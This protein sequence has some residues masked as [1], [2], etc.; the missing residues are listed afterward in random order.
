[1]HDGE[2]SES[3]WVHDTDEHFRMC[4]EQGAVPQAVVSLDGR[5]LQVN[6]ALARLLGV[7]CSELIGKRFNDVTHPDDR[8][9]SDAA[10]HTLLSGT[11]MIRM[12]ERYLTHDGA[13]V[14]ADVNVALVRSPN[15]HPQ[16]FVGTYID[17]TA[18]KLAEEELEESRNRLRMALDSARMGTW[19]WDL[20]SGLRGFDAQVC[21]LLGIDKASF[22]GQPDEFFRVVHPDDH[23]KVK[24]AL[25]RTIETGERYEIEYRVLG[26]DGEIGTVAA[27]GGLVR[28]AAGKPLRIDGVVWDRSEQAR[29]LQALRESEERFRELAEALP[30]TIFEID[31]QGR[32]YYSNQQGLR[33]FGVS[34]AEIQAGLLVRN[35]VSPD[36]QPAVQQRVRERLQGRPQGVLEFRALRRN[37]ETFDALAYA[38]LIV[39]QGRP[40]GLCGVV[41][42]ISDRKQAERALRQTN[43]Q[44]EEATLCARVMAAQAEK[45]NAAKSEFLANMSHELRTPLNGVIG[46]TGLLCEGSLTHEQ[47]RRAEIVR[48]NGEALMA[49]IDDILDFAKIEA[50]ELTLEWLAFD[51][52]SLLDDVIAIMSLRAEGKP[53]RI[54]CKIDPDLPSLLRG[55]PGR[56][57]QVLYNIVGNAVKFTEQGEVVLQVTTMEHAGRAVLIRFS[58]CDTGIGLSPDKLNLVFQRFTQI[59]GSSTRRHG[60]VGLGLA[61]CKG[62]VELMGGSIGVE[63]QEGRGSR[64]WFTLPFQKELTIDV[65]NPEAY[66]PIAPP[67]QAALSLADLRVL[68]A[69]DNITNQQ[70]AS[71][72]LANLGVRVDCVANGREALG[73]LRSRRYDLVLMDVEMPEMDGLAATRALRA[74]SEGATDKTVPVVAMTA[75]ALPSDRERCLAAGMDDYITKPVSPTDLRN[76]TEKWIVNTPPKPRVSETARAA[77]AR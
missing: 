68:V 44:L 63:S 41:M 71:A 75:H 26:L 55:Y 52:R 46:M 60:G 2:A 5:F 17:V 36:D 72:I 43:Q 20:E 77:L 27:R 38:S 76:M 30:Q 7:P 51:L 10:L 74:A 23:A 47:R 67:S 12:E 65:R 14:W 56:L 29:S 61:I 49:L 25:A 64:F 21:S 39:R 57:R 22:F 18:R 66:L 53:L 28:D 6:P 32:V 8:A 42:D 73:A 37:G 59:D 70:V 48:R 45:A 34:P 62:L 31:L 1:M 35:L 15:G 58:V 40:V 16:Y 33:M 50:G 3:N 24:A 13:T 9:M 4:F 54:V 11:D 19:H 69:E